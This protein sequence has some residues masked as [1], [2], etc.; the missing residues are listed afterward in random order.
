MMADVAWLA[1]CDERWL[2]GAVPYRDFIEINPPASLL[3]YLP[4]VAAARALGLRSELCVAVF[5]FLSAGAAMALSSRRAAP[6]RAGR[7]ARRGGGA[8]RV[9]GRDLLRARP[10][11]GGVRHAA[12]G[13]GAR[14]RRGRTAGAVAGAG[15]RG[16]G[17]ADG[18]DQA[19]LCAGRRRAGAL[20]G[21]AHRLARGFAGAGIL[22]GG[23]GGSGLCRQ[24]RAVLS[25]LCR[26]RD[27]ARRGGLCAGAREP[28]GALG[29]TGA[30]LSCS[31]P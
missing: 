17:G 19:A 21:G 28:D 8:R 4:A 22:R 24:R 14:P 11:G 2:D 6:G 18:G 5:G 12:S 1:H 3:L 13:A 16:R 27:A 29:S 10:S 15:G 26:Q 23:G 20:S 7:R 31:S 25:G 9:A 30:I